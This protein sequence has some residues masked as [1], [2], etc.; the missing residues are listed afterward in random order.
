MAAGAAAR[1]APRPSSS[2][3]AAGP[4]R[5][6]AKPAAGTAVVGVGRSDLTDDDFRARMRRAVEDAAE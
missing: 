3:C 2:G 6:T 5:G 4:E 1:S